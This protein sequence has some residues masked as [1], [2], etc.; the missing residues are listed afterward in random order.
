MPY[1]SPDG[2]FASIR[3]VTKCLVFSAWNV[4]PDAIASLSSYEAERIM[5][6]RFP[7]PLSYGELY[8]ELR[9]LLRYS[10]TEGRL[11]GMTVLILLYPSPALAKLVDPLKIA[12]SYGNN[13][14]IPVR[15]LIDA[16]TKFLKPSLNSL[17]EGVANSGPE[18]RR[19][20]WALPALLD[21][22]MFP[23][24]KCWLGDGH[25]S[26][27]SIATDGPR[28]RGELFEEHLRLFRQSM[29]QDIHPPLGRPPKDLLQVVS[30]MALAAPGVCALRALK[31]QSPGLDWDSQDLLHGAVRISEGFRTLFNLPESIALLR[32]DERDESYWMLALRHCL[33]GNIQSLLDEQCHCL[34]ESLGVIDESEA[35]R[36]RTIGDSLGSSLSLSALHS[37][38]LTK[39]LSARGWGKLILEAITRVAGSLCGSANSKTI[40]APPSGR[41]PCGTL[42]TRLSDRL[43]LLRRPS[44]KK[45]LIFTH[46]V[47]Q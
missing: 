31:R 24:M 46:G 34:V 15:A 12:M 19:W 13:G 27:V 37:C 40:R 44:G 14:L 39:C 1:S 29:D 33:E 30:S 5:L 43:F 41:T 21:G 23:G 22:K 10:R 9:P 20:Y 8:N 16:A 3:E 32:G 45:A 17:L 42:L 38:S 47:I 2:P 18:D 7:R 6:S 11:S 28:E 4:V 25:D 26:W 36:C 35:E